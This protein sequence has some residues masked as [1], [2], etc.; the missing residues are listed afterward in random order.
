LY[1]T[2]LL[3]CILSP[4]VNNVSKSFS[5]NKLSFAREQELYLSAKLSS[6]QE[7]GFSLPGNAAEKTI[8]LVATAASIIEKLMFSSQLSY[9]TK[10][11]L[12][13]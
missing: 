10:I 1:E 5:P 13:P 8:F 11:Q 3:N 7:H 4:D 12:A 6:A 9:S 2:A